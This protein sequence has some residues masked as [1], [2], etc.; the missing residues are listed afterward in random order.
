MDAD[1][2]GVMSLPQGKLMA[3]EPG[4]TQLLHVGPHVAAPDIMQK[5]GHNSNM[6]TEGNLT[7]L[8]HVGPH[9]AAP[10]ITQEHGQ[11]MCTQQSACRLKKGSPSFRLL[12]RT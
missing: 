12:G 10:D 11:N 7:Q 8:S 4:L 9:V 2:P 1:G 3:G 5:Q 6:Q